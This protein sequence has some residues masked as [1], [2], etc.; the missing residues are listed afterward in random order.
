MQTI[1]GDTCKINN[2]HTYIAWKN[3]WDFI[4]IILVLYNAIFIPVTIAF[5]S[6]EGESAV[7]GYFIDTLFIIDIFLSFRTA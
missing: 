5:P 1:C 4:I 2:I 6:Y 3:Q 7:V